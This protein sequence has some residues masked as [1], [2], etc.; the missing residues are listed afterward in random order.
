MKKIN[1]L[2]WTGANDGNQIMLELL[3]ENE[4]ESYVE[5]GFDQE[6]GFSPIKGNANMSKALFE[7][8]GEVI[9]DPAHSDFTMIKSNIKVTALNLIELL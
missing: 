7:M 3:D 1:R 2:V 5:V 4:K 9:S 6:N 8:L